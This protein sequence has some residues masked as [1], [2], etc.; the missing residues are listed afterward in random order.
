[1]GQILTRKPIT[2]EAVGQFY[3]RRI[4]RIVPTC[5]FVILA[6]VIA[7]NSLVMQTDSEGLPA[8]TLWALTF[9]T[10]LQDPASIGVFMHLWS[11]GVEMQF[12]LII[13]G[14]IWLLTKAEIGQAAHSMVFSRI[15][16]FFAGISAHYVTEYFKIKER[17]NYSFLLTNRFAV[18]LGDLSYVWYLV[19]F[20]MILIIRYRYSTAFSAPEGLIAFSASLVLAYMVNLL[21]DWHFRQIR[22]FKTVLFTISLLFACTLSMI[23][24]RYWAA[25]SNEYTLRWDLTQRPFQGEL[26]NDSSYGY[27][28]NLVVKEGTFNLNK[29]TTEEVIAINKKMS[30]NTARYIKY[31]AARSYLKELNYSAEN[32]QWDY[33]AIFQGTG[34]LSMLLIGDSHA[35]QITAELANSF[36]SK[37]KTLKTY[38]DADCL[39]FEINYYGHD[40]YTGN[41]INYSSAVNKAIFK[42]KP[43]IIF[44]NF[45]WSS[46]GRPPLHSLIENDSVLKDIE[47]WLNKLS[48]AAKVVYLGAPSVEFYDSVGYELPKRMWMNSPL[49]SINLKYK[50][51][52]DR[53]SVHWARMKKLRC[54]KCV[55]VGWSK[56]FCD[57]E[58]YK[59]EDERACQAYNPTNKLAYFFD[60]QHCSYYGI[61]KFIPILDQLARNMDDDLK[62]IQKLINLF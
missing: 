53:E 52:I 31:T 37:Y 56:A 59:G 44:V 19:H 47:V 55:F 6:T 23:L 28:F 14:L 26:V 24:H 32:N 42:M 48:Q 61:T 8:D 30:E 49:D 39:P 33:Q 50:D 34:E 58:E 3:S 57:S 40:R 27:K 46:M 10:N 9:A 21:A 11:L 54:L 51:F 18:E 2:F 45:R 13:P 15:W 38:T 43:D 7:T 4:H 60:T 62:R 41:C 17:R 20:P 12:Y 5:L 36:S 29:L 35:G 1:M 16:Q 22:Q 25:H